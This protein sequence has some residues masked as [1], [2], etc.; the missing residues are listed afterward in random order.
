MVTMFDRSASYYDAIYRSVGNDYAADADRAHATIL[1][2][3]Q[4]RGHRLL[5]V[6]CGTGGHVEHLKLHYEVEGVDISPAMLDIASRRNPDVTFHLADM[7]HLQLGT[8]FDAVICLFSSIGYVKTIEALHQTIEA[9][10]R[11]TVPGGVV[12][13]D[14]WLQPEQWRPRY[15]SADLVDEPDLKI[16]RLS[17][18]EQ[19]GTLSIMEMHHLVVT[20]DGAD[21]FV[22]RHEMGLFTSAQYCAAFEQAGLVV[23]YDPDGGYRGRGGYVGVRPNDQM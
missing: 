8:T 18:S 13:V 15:L 5:D 14:G 21:T 10:A 16:A 22:E 2:T 7:T 17:R 20:R 19:N 12:L 1:A 11:H 23:T 6:A 4:S 9:F 3:K